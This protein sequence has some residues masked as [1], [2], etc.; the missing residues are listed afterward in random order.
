MILL[1]IWQY[2]ML[3]NCH[4]VK[5]VACLPAALVKLVFIVRVVILDAIVDEHGRVQSF[6]VLRGHP[7]LAKAATEA[8]RQWEYEPLRLNGT[9]TPFELTVSLWFHFDDKAK[10][11]S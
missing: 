8:V 1:V 6:K 5:R 2:V 9:A 4:G 10:K 11:R 3:P 7:L